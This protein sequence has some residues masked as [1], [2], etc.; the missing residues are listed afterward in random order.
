MAVYVQGGDGG[1][2]SA[3]DVVVNASAVVTN[4]KSD[5]GVAKDGTEVATQSK[6][7][8]VFII[9]SYAHVKC[10]VS[11]SGARR[12]ALQTWVHYPIGGTCVDDGLQCADVIL[13]RVLH[14]RPLWWRGLMSNAMTCMVS[15]LTPLWVHRVKHPWLSKGPLLR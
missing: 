7:V 15:K 13:C 12:N 11:H 3:C 2:K 10:C 14:M 6:K 4:E 5:E 9:D 8:S 1:R